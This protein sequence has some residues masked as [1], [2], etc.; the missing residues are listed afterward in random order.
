MFYRQDSLSFKSELA[1]RPD[2]TLARVGS[3]FTTPWRTL[4]IARDAVGLI[5]SYLIL[6]LNEPCALEDVSW[7]RPHKYVG[8]WWGMH[9]GTQ[10]W[11]MGPRHG[12]TTE[13]ALR[14]I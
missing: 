5:N 7:I 9:L 1:P 3:K 8:V 13:N 6:N 2:G 10:V 4:Q 14:P 12:A 11:T